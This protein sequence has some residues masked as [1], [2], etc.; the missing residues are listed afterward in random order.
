MFELSEVQILRKAKELCRLDCKTWSTH[1][2]ENGVD[3]VTMFTVVA[4]DSARTEY[5]NMA[6]ALL[7]KKKE[8]LLEK[9]KQELLGKKSRFVADLDAHF[10]LNGTPGLSPF[11][12]STAADSR[13]SCIAA[14]VRGISCLPDSKR[15]TV[16]APTTARAANSR[17][18]KPS[19]ARAILHWI[20][21]IGIFVLI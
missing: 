21:C 2:F 13:T 8:E 18:P 16:F 19:A 4:D 10:F 12:N 17:M 3:G 11:V 20:G 15:A 9:K 5:L 14:T 1:D 6:K 7:E